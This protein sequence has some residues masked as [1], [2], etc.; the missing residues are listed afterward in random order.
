M[1]AQGLTTAC[2]ATRWLVA[3]RKKTGGQF[4]AWKCYACPQ[5]YSLV[6]LASHLAIPF[7]RMLVLITMLP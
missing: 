4:F 5:A 2:S 6:L 3:H 1:G 7:T